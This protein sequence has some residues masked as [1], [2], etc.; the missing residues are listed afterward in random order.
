MLLVGCSLLLNGVKTRKLV[1]M[2]DNV[3]VVARGVESSQV[4]LTTRTLHTAYV[5]RSEGIGTYVYVAI[6]LQHGPTAGQS[7]RHKNFFHAM[8]PRIRR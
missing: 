1:G 4:V 7:M 3:R 8:H 2:A 6:L 5:R